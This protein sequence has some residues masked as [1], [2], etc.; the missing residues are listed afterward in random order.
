LSVIEEAIRSY[1]LPK[2]GGSAASG[3]RPS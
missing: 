2:P 1:E 3:R